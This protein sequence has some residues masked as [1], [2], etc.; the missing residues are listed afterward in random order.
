MGEKKPPLNSIQDDENLCRICK[1]EP[2][3]MNGLCVYCYE[4][5]FY[6]NDDFEDHKKD[7]KMKIHSQ[8]IKDPHQQKIGRKRNVSKITKKRK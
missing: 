4:E 1:E 7:S 5:D 2:V 6:G 8:A 3:F